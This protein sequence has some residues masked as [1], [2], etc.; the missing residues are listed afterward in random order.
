[1]FYSKTQKIKGI[2]HVFLRWILRI[3]RYLIV[4]EAQKTIKRIL[5]KI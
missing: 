4:E 2:Q 5:K 1:M 3:Y